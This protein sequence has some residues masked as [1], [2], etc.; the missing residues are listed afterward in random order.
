MA[1]GVVER[2]QYCYDKQYTGAW[3][4]AH[5]LAPAIASEQGSAGWRLRFST[6]S[7]KELEEAMELMVRL[8]GANMDVEAAVEAELLQLQLRGTL[9]LAMTARQ[10]LEGKGTVFVAPCAGTGGR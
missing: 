1:R 7:D 3:P 9:P 10:E 2:F 6:L 5:L 8:A 4:P